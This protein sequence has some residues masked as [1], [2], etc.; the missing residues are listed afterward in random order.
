M[1]PVHVGYAI[2][3]VFP[4]TYQL[5]HPHSYDISVVQSL[6]SFISARTITSEEPNPY[7]IMFALLPTRK[8]AF[9]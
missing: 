9:P 7:H 8:R 2:L 3:R 4:Y 6:E 1:P 5:P